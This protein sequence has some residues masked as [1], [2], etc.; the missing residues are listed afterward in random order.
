[1]DIQ[2]NGQPVFYVPFTDDQCN[3]LIKVSE[4]HYDSLCKSYSQPGGFLFGLRNHLTYNQNDPDLLGYKTS[5]RDLD[6]LMKI[7]EIA[8]LSI[9]D[10]DEKAVV[11][12]MQRDFRR[13]F[14]DAST[15]CKDWVVISKE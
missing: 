15:A 5:W 11:L 14:K 12:G 8:Y 1:M 9:F 10:L 7:L 6:I 2:I 3:I 13:A 4:R